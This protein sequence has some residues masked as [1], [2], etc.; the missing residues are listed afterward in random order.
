MFFVYYTTK[1]WR[2]FAA[3]HNNITF[4]ADVEKTVDKSLEKNI[5]DAYFIQKLIFHKCALQILYCNVLF[6]AYRS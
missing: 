5:S 2:I 3:R 1:Q 4:F 6:L